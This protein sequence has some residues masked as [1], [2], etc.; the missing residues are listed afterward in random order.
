MEIKCN[1]L[2]SN[3]EAVNGISLPQR[4]AVLEQK[5]IH[6]Q[7]I[8]P[9]PCAEFAVFLSRVIHLGSWPPTLV[10][11]LTHVLLLDHTSH[12]ISYGITQH[13]DFPPHRRNDVVTSQRSPRCTAGCIIGCCIMPGYCAIP[14][15]CT[16]PACCIVIPALL[17]P[18]S[19]ASAHKVGTILLES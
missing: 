10:I 5:H 6:Q 18:R 15:C 8:I 3:R 9:P 7:R 4:A 19:V 17:Y 11:T 1:S 2:T 16:I 13:R 14:A 12:I